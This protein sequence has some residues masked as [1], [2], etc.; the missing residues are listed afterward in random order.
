MKT[1]RLFSYLVILLLYRISLHVQLQVISLSKSFVTVFKKDGCKCYVT[2]C[3]SHQPNI[4]VPKKIGILQILGKIFFFFHKFLSMHFFKNL[5]NTCTITEMKRNLLHS[6]YFVK[7]KR[8]FFFNNWLNISLDDKSLIFYRSR[9]DSSL[10]VIPHNL[11]RN[12]NEFLKSL[13]IQ[14]FMW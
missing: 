1:C 13:S 9:D 11:I 3:F 14:F 8:F 10:Q 7:I 6:F 12:I 4:A 5:N 2:K